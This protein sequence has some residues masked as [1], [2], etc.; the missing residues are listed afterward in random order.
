MK[1]WTNSPFDGPVPIGEIV[2]NSTTSRLIRAPGRL[3]A[4]LLPSGP[5]S[6]TVGLLLSAVLPGGLLILAALWLWRWRRG[7]R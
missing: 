3:V 7:G 1:E 4:R 2:D 5:M 6:P